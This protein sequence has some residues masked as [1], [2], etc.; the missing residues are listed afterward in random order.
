M[1]EVWKG[2]LNQIDDVTF[3]IPKNYKPGMRVPGIIF[4]TKKLMESIVQDKAPEQVANVAHLPGILKASLAMPDIHW[5][6]GFPIGGV[7]AMDENEGVISPGGVGYDINCG[8]RVLRT[9]LKKEEVEP[10]LDKLLD[11]LFIN[12]PSGVGAKGKLRVSE[13]DLEDV[14]VMGAKW[15]VKKGFG[16]EEDLKRTESYGAMPGADPSPVS[17]KARERGMPQLGTL[18]SG[19]HFLE[20]QVVEKIFDEESAKKMGLF[21][22]QVCLMIHCGSRGFGHQIADDFIKIM[23]NAMRKYNIDLPDKQLA[24]APINSKEAKDYIKAMTAAANF[25]WCNR[26]MI[27]HWVRESFEK[28][29]GKSSEELGIYMV[30]DVAHNI[31]KREKHVINGKERWVWVHRKGATRAFPPHHPEIPEIYKEIGQP[32]LIPGSMGTGSYILVGTKT[33]MEKSFG[34]TCHGAGRVLSRAA[35]VR[36]SKGRNIEAELLKIGVKI[37]AASRD[38][39]EEEI[40]D[41]YKDLDIVVDVVDRAGIS[42]KVARLKPF[43]VVKG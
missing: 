34:S 35:A 29:F 25:A 17:K 5:G 38:T 7:A 31:A 27:A 6:Y 2:P 13:R 40:P 22:G 36:A 10:Y 30:Y 24:C 11:T 19:N 9:N 43:G 42:K 18:G 12:V 14:M 37:R 20:L 39:M 23:L 41:A 1:S 8:V 4:A 16:T 3:E 28:V 15:A 32:V 26:Q 21:L 33:A